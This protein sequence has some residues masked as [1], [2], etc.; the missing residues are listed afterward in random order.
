MAKHTCSAWSLNLIVLERPCKRS[1]DG[2]FAEKAHPRCKGKMFRYLLSKGLE[3][4]CLP[5]LYSPSPA[6][7]AVYNKANNR[8]KWRGEALFVQVPVRYNYL[9]STR[10]IFSKTAKRVIPS[11]SISGLQNDCSWKKDFDEQC[12]RQGKYS[13]PCCSAIVAPSRLCRP[14]T[15]AMARATTTSAPSR[16]ST[17]TTCT[18]TSSRSTCTQVRTFPTSSFFAPNSIGKL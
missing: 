13:S 6:Y 10:T 14:L 16:S 1:G 11:L 3:T 17:S 15:M 12:H 8:Q 2:P 5:H 4:T 7:P 18:R 9:Y